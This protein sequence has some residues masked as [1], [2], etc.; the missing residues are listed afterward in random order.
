MSRY[1][2]QRLR[3]FIKLTSKSRM[4]DEED[5]RM[6]Y[7]CFLVLCK[8]LIQHRKITEEE[9][10]A[11][12]WGGFHPED[13]R[14]MIP[15]LIASYPH[16][17]KAQLFDYEDVFKVAHAEFTSGHFTAFTLED[18]WE[19]SFIDEPA[20]PDPMFQK[21][22][23]LGTQEGRTTDGEWRGRECN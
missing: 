17:P 21:W 22:F 12:F 9:C 3:E 10:N 5:V 1:S 16:H 14:L 19:P 4:A 15:Q 2:K 8:P 20:K 6:Y 11:A 7:K 13:R 18:D 23:N